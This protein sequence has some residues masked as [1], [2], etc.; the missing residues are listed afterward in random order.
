[1][2]RNEFEL[3]YQPK[4]DSFSGRSEGVEASLRWRDP[5]HGSVSP[6]EFIPSAERTGLIIPSGER[7]LE[8][9]CAQSAEWRAN[10]DVSGPLA[11][12]VAALQIERSDYVTSSAAASERHGLP[13][14]SSEVE[15]TESSSMESQ[16]QACA[17]SAQSQAMGV[18]T[19]VDD[20]G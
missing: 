11:I 10:G 16:Q 12:N 14:S 7:V 9:A 6:G 15:I 3:W 19:A 4:V 18:A 13:A 5:E 8:S 1:M 20:F 17:V 2:E